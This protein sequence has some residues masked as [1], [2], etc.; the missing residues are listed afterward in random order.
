MSPGPLLGARG[1]QL[2]DVHRTATEDVFNAVKLLRGTKMRIIAVVGIRSQYIKLH[3]IQS[4]LKQL[5]TLSEKIEMI[6]IDAGQHYD[7]ELSDGFTDELGIQFDDRLTYDTNNPLGIFS[8]MIFK[9]SCLYRKYNVA[10][11]VDYIMVFG[12]ANTTMAASIAA[13]KTGIQLI[14]VE[15]GLR[16]G[17]LKSPEEGN[18]IVADHLASKLFVS[19]KADWKNIKREGLSEKSYFSG[20][21]IQD[22]VLHLKNNGVLNGSISY[23]PETSC[24][25]QPYAVDDFIIAS[26]HRK[27]NL[28][29]DC[30]VPL[31]KALDQLPHFVI[32]IA[33]PTML[34]R[35]NRLS[36]DREK[37]AVAKYI[38][39]HDMLACINSC[40]YLITDSGAFQREAYYLSKRCLIRQDVAF[41]QHLVDIGVHEQVGS[42]YTDFCGGIKKIE[43]ALKKEY[44]KTDYFGTGDAVKAIFERLLG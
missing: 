14:H 34:K 3:A 37:I 33:H 9:L 5:D 20:D 12:D 31:F 22:L 18:R 42:T 38:P 17:S 29:S 23:L 4:K 2:G 35:I 10:A 11:P 36:F 19:N 13:S 28:E 7:Y 16:L 8:E 30:I 6:Y 21:V 26:L 43:S 32:F 40:R 44:P 1:G 27:E 15:A 25:L 24:T 41:W 39:Y